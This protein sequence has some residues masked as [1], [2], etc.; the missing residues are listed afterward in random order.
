MQFE[1]LSEK[2]ITLVHEKSLEILSKA[3]IKVDSS[4]VLDMMEKA[5]CDV[6]RENSIIRFPKQIIEKSLKQSPGKF[7]LGS[8]DGNFDIFL[9]EGNTFFYKNGQGCFSADLET[10]EGRYPTMKDLTDAARLA[11]SL[12]YISCFWSIVTANDVNSDYRSLHEIVE[13]WKV[14][15]K[16]ITADCFNESQAKY[17]IE[18]LE[19]ILGSREEIAKRNILSVCCCSISPLI[20]D[21]P[22]LEGTILLGDAGVPVLLLPMPI[23]GTTSPMSSFSTVIQNNAEV[24]A[25]IAIL[26]T[27]N[28]G[29]PIIYGSA[30]GILDMSTSLFCAGSPEGGL[31]NAACA[32]MAK[33]YGI[34]NLI[35]AGGADA[36][37]P[38]IQA[39][40]ERMAGMLPGFLSGSDLICGVGLTGTAQY[41]YL[42]ELIIGEDIVG[43]CRRTAAGIGAGEEHCL[44]ELAVETGHGGDFLAEE[45]T[46][47]YLRS[48]EIYMPKNFCRESPES[49]LNSEKK[50]LMLF[51]EKKVN[52]VLS[53]KDK[54][55]YSEELYQSLKEILKR[56][57]LG[58]N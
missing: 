53:K 25:G 40:T 36:Q 13:I 43:F 27:A 24:L 3:G 9:C 38:G 55:N 46:V 23:S 22:M 50:D 26:Q 10:R 2:D 41:L 51:A 16:H 14:S 4:K 18:V 15:S 5:G 29:R 32:Q 48:G 12:D 44:T 49:W 21:G 20:Y 33:K 52:E 54:D 11:N 28:P 57:D 34:P 8:L 6:C 30:P 17:F 19:K 47:E 7:M 35:S 37:A 42:E 58:A 56:A 31:Q 45:S 39:A 1:V